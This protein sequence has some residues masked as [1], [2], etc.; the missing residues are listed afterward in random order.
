MRAFLA[1]LPDTETALAI[2]HWR[3][4]CW[5][6]MPG[7]VPVQNLH[8]TLVFLGDIDSTQQQALESILDGVEMPPIELSLSSLG[9]HLDR[10]MLWLEPGSE[11]DDDRSVLI[12][13][14][15]SL[16]RA[17]ARAGIAVDKGR[18][19]PHMTLARRVMTPPPSPLLDADVVFRAEAMHLV[20]S[21]LQP[22][23]PLYSVVRSWP[24]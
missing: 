13:V 15:D 1:L 24:V 2:D 19:R 9:F 16:R 23:G 3:N 6:N 10:N 17:A 20:Q 18:Y 21:R 11:S 4:L 5:R 7:V 8:I 22:D 12:G 14:V